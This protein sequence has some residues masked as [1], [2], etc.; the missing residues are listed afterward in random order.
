MK[1]T[2][3]PRIAVLVDL[4][5]TASAGGHVKYWERLGAAAARSHLPFDLTI[6]FSGNEKTFNLAPH[7]RFRQLRPV[8][9][10]SRL[11]FLP[12]MPDSSD[13]A[14]H[15]KKL[16]EELQN[17]DLFHSTDGFFAFARTAEKIS[18]KKNVPLVTSFHTDT[19]S[20]TRIFTRQF[21]EE[22]FGLN[23]LGRKLLNDWRWP[24]RQ[25]NG[26][27]TRLKRHLRSSKRALAARTQDRQLAESVLGEANVH[28]IRL[29]IDRTMFAAHKRDKAGIEAKYAI[30]QGHII[31]LF[32]GRLDV[33]KNIYT[34]IEAVQK[35]LRA[36]V[37]VHLIAVGQGPAATDIHEQLGRH[38]SVP[39]YMQAEELARLYASVDLLT[40]PSEVE[41]CNMTVVEAL[42]SGCPVMVSE[43]SG[44]GPVFDA[45]AAIHIV[46]GGTESWTEALSNFAE[47]GDLRDEMRRAA[48]R[49]GTTQLV[50]WNEVLEQDLYPVWNLALTKSA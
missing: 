22:K 28:Q 49:Y 18:R 37:P 48:G 7:V 40:L 21:I 43:R 1:P 5:R 27:L 30:M 24:E 13:L 44:I 38:A 25:Q 45:G 2:S 14:L 42:A 39:G 19:P 33:G 50:G 16:A 20:Y 23:W 29:G 35:L 47:N 41:I 26:M 8:F 36:R 34:L 32:V 4:P 3:V 9:S 10:S 46:P 17:Y 11:R 15:H 12:Y 31:L 6:Y